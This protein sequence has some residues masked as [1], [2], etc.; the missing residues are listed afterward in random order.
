[1]RRRLIASLRLIFV[2]LVLIAGLLVPRDVRVAAAPLSAITIGRLFNDTMDTRLSAQRVADALTTSGYATSYRGGRS[3]TDTWS[4]GQRSAVLALFGHSN[5]AIFQTDEGPTDPEDEIIAAGTT[6]TLTA[7]TNTAGAT[8]GLLDAGVSIVPAHWAFWKDYL[9]YV[10]V[11]DVLVAILAGCFTANTDPGLGN[12]LDVGRE[13]GMDSLVGWTGLVFYPSGGCVDCNYSG[14]YFWDRFASYVPTGDTVS[15]A[16]AK[17]RADLVT[18]EGSAGGWDTWYVRGAAAFPADVR[19][20]PASSGQPLNSKPFGIEPF[21]PLSLP[22]ANASPTSIGG[23]QFT[24]VQAQGGVFYRLDP[25]GDLVALIAPSST[26]GTAELTEQDALSRAWAFAAQ[27]VAW[28]TPSRLVL[29]SHGATSRAD[30]DVRYAFTWRSLLGG[31]P[32]P[33]LLTIEVD[34][35]TGSVIYLVATDVKPEESAFAL[36]RADA[37]RIA[38]RF[39]TDWSRVDASQDVWGRPRWVVRL[40][41]DRDARFPDVTE[42][43]VDGV[44]GSIL[45]VRKT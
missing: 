44:T 17:A 16:L 9:P 26:Q 29:L 32:G 37:I 34:A 5:A 18:K 24:D 3:A 11:D 33:A 21:H 8:G 31:V 4:D 20:A 28:I 42:V 43:L 19:L 6:G 13:R 45:S 2:A 12:F 10:D 14:N 30:G 27:D 38:G 40:Y 23:S 15:V 35:R 25:S 22:I 1:M 39:A 36:S 41:R 7:Q